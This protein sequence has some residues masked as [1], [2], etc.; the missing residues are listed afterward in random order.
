MR[1]RIVILAIAIVLAVSAWVFQRNHI[2]DAI[3]LTGIVTTNDV[4]VSS[5]VTG[6]LTKLFVDEGS[7]VQPDQVVATLEPGELQADRAY[8]ARSADAMSSQVAASEAEL[9]ASLAQRSEAQAMLADA[10]R[11]LERNERLLKSDYM[12][13]KEVEASRTAFNVAQARAEAADQQ[14]ATKRSAVTA[15]KQ[16]QSAAR[17]QTEKASVRLSYSE[18]RAPIGG[19]VD[20]RAARVGEVVAAGQPIVTLVNPDSLWVRAD[21]EESYIDRVRLG[22]HLAVVLPS[23]AQLPGTVFYRGVDAE[24]ATQ[25]DVSRIKRDV[26]TFQVR[27]RVDNKERRLAVGMTAHVLL[28]IAAQ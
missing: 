18:I 25:R 11:Q 5:Q 22:D 16:Q 15:L 23:G 13:E 2:P 10:K 6:R 1:K 14:V 8:F 17:A 19:T 12:S 9:A 20:V 26:K 24:Y 7:E 21:V 4:I 27:L 3:N 28:P